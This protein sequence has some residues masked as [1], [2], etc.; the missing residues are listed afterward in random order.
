MA[1]L[2]SADSLHDPWINASALRFLVDKV[3]EAASVASLHWRIL[4]AKPFW[5]NALRVSGGD[6]A[7]GGLPS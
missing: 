5:R 4:A 7:G 2:A 6:A 3:G 1:R